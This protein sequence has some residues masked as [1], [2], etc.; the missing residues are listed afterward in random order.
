MQNNNNY[1]TQ[2]LLSNLLIPVFRIIKNIQ[3]STVH[4]FMADIA[5]WKVLDRWKSIEPVH[6][7][8]TFYGAA[9]I[10]SFLVY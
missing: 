10:A 2:F 9:K 4:N 7:L 1:C 8:H 3:N 5:Q 6:L